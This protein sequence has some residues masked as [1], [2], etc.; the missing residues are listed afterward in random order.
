MKRRSSELLIVSRPLTT[1]STL[2]KFS[3]CTTP[4]DEPECD[5]ASLQVATK[6][7]RIQLQMGYFF[8]LE[9]PTTY[10]PSGDVDLGNILK[11]DGVQVL[12]IDQ[13]EYSSSPTRL[14]TNLS[15][16]AVVLARRCE[17]GRRHA[18]LPCNGVAVLANN[19]QAFV[20]SIP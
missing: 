6:A 4:S 16:A 19:H 1:C 17:R 18:Q 10:S 20:F 12:E 9:L 14:L 15:L 8:I 2:N 13:C 11:T 3:Q 7:C 5:V